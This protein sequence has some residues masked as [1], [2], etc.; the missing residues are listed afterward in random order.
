MVHVE[1]SIESCEWKQFTAFWFS[2][3][4][5]EK[6]MNLWFCP[7][8]RR[9]MTDPHPLFHF[10]DPQRVLFTP[11]P[12]WSF[13]WRSENETC[14]LLACQLASSC[15]TKPSVIQTGVL[16]CVNLSTEHADTRRSDRGKARKKKCQSLLEL[17]SLNT[18]DQ[19]EQNALLKSSK[20]C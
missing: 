13:I 16:W 1:Y 10:S 7:S 5:Q 8:G 17:C 2:V 4:T 15:H 9:H 14:Q 20:L 19:T 18:I 3:N 6:K 12:T 11:T